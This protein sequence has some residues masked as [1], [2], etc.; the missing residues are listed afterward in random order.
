MISLR[1]RDIKKAL[2]I[3]EVYSLIDFLNNS[4]PIVQLIGKINKKR[5]LLT[6]YSNLTLQR[7]GWF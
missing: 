3:E 6:K 5:Y 1:K 7:L 2:K 4:K